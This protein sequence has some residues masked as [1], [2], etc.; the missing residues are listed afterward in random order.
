MPIEMARLFE[1]LDFQLAV[2]WSSTGPAFRFH[3]GPSEFDALPGVNKWLQQ[4]YFVA[5][6]VLTPR[7]AS[8]VEFEM[9]IEVGT[10]EEGLALL[11]YFIGREVA[12]VDKPPWLRIAERLSAHLPWRNPTDFPGLFSLLRGKTR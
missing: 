12:E 1:E 4:T 7:S 10:Y 5:G 3:C 11:G 6:T 8:L 2:S 9:P